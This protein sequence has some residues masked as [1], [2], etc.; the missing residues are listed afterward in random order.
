[1]T[2]PSN[3]REL[4]TG[5]GIGNYNATMM[6]PYTFIAPAT[7]DPKSAQMILMVQAIQKAL[8]DLGA[9]DVPLSGR[10]DVPTANALASVVGPDWERTT[11]GGNIAKI[12]AFRRAGGRLKG[13]VSDAVSAPVAIGGPLDFLPD[14]PGGLLTYAVVG[15]FV[16]RHFTRKARA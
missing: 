16:Y 4:L 2:I 10:L 15:Y 7:T 13:A 14:V 6:I 3:A 11:W 9:H 12:L 8:F 5:I 1:M